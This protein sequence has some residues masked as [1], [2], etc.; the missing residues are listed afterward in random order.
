MAEVV[1]IAKFVAKEGCLVELLDV[2]AVL[3]P[4]VQAEEPGCLRYA[5]HTEAG[6]ETGRS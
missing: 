3:A 6:E 2:L 1:L 5:V 4:R